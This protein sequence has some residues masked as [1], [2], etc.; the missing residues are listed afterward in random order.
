MVKIGTCNICGLVGPLSFEHV[1]P[2]RAYNDQRIF[3]ANIQRMVAE[4]WD[5]QQRPITGKWAQRGAGKHTLCNRCNNDTGAWYGGA[6]VSW[7][8]QGVELLER[9]GGKLTLAYPYTIFPLRVF[10]QV[11]AMFF[12]ACGPNLRLR[13]PDL[14]QFVL[15]RDEQYMP[16]DLRVFAYLLHPD[17]TGAFRQSGMSGVVK[18]YNKRHVFAEI[19]FPPFGFLLTG[20][21]DPIYPTLLD[22]TYLSHARYSHRDGVFLRLPVLPVNTWLPGDFRSKEEIRKTV[23]NKDVVGRV[24]L[25]VLR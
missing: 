13:F 19:A 21:R 3:E 10:K 24:E 16:H 23:E 6:Y 25:D 5:G 7:A 4:K 12:S 15:Q 2:R 22:I 1:P 14:V 9:S 8:R 18:D 11:V 17:D 20:D